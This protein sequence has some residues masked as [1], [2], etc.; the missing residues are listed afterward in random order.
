MKINFNEFFLSK[1]TR[2][3][4]CAFGF[5]LSCLFFVPSIQNLVLDFGECLIGRSLTRYVWVERFIKCGAHLCLLFICVAICSTYI[6]NVSKAKIIVKR[7]S[8][9]LCKNERIFFIASLSI[10]S[11]YTSDAADD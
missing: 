2:L 9:F 4:L 3:V 7:M 8:D 1:K 10:F 6:E 5:V 11:L